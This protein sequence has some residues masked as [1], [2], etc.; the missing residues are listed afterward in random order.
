MGAFLLS[1][2]RSKVSAIVTLLAIGLV[3]YLVTGGDAERPK[4]PEQKNQKLIDDATA[5]IGEDAAAIEG[6]TQVALASDHLKITGDWDRYRIREL[7]LEDGDLTVLT[8]QSADAASRRQAAK[9]C[10]TLLGGDPP[11]IEVEDWVFIFGRGL[12]P[13]RAD[14]CDTR[15]WREPAAPAGS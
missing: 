12:E 8:R 13:I 9:L 3:V 14:E 4:A 11:L 6:A 5:G 10:E 15:F 2:I 7:R 1:A